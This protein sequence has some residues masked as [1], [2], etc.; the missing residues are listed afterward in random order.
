VSV[1]IGDVVVYGAYGVGRVVALEQNC[2][3]GTER[4]CIVIELAAGL[5]VTLPVEDAAERLRAVVNDAE[6]AHVQKTLAGEATT[7]EESWTR[8]IKESR[9]K[10]AGGR[11]ADLAELVR[12]GGRLERLGYPSR[13][14]NGERRLYVQA[15]QLLAR[16][17]GSARG[18]DEGDADAWIETQIG[19]SEPRAT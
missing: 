11:A 13:L 3:A 7:R 12:D 16:E 14:S 1:A 9:A 18:I 6:L 15:R 2:V 4:E 19:R 5:R 8:R 10:L 17:I